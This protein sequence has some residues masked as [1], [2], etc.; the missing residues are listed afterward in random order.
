MPTKRM[1]PGE[2]QWAFAG[3]IP[4]NAPG[5]SVV[6][7]SHAADP[8]EVDRYPWSR[9]F[10]ISEA[11]VVFDDVFVPNDRVFLDGEVEHSAT[12]AHSL[13]M[14]ERLGALAHTVD[15]ADLLVGLAQLIAEANG[16]DRIAHI[17][18]KIGDLIIYAT[19]LRASLDAAIDHADVTA[20]GYATPSELYTNAA[21]FHAAKN[22]SEMV[23]NLHD[24]AGGAV[25]TAPS[26]Y[27]LARV[28]HVVRRREVPLHQHRGRDAAEVRL[29]LFHAI[30][31]LTA[32]AYGGWRAVT[33]LLGGG[34]LHAQRM[35]TVKHYDLDA[36]SRRRETQH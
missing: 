19:M 30:R 10:A 5:V 6:S 31:D 29:R 2:E 15:T 25:I 9:R 20:E 34:G 27:D 3:A 36:R 26:L 18:Q 4:V 35:V 28:Q 24:I 1:Q 11:L 21:K 8:S 16:T 14:W 13:G 32:D 17:R 22:F 7:T 33:L 12:W 23:R